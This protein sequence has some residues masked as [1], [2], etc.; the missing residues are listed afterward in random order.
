M[1]G[2]RI[3]RR[4]CQDR[5]VCC[6]SLTPQG[7]G[8]F[9]FSTSQTCVCTWSTCSRKLASLQASTAILEYTSPGTCKYLSD[10]QCP[11]RLTS[12][13]NGGGACVQRV[14][15]LTLSQFETQFSQVNGRKTSINYTW[16]L[17]HTQLTNLLGRHHNSVNVKWSQIR[18][19]IMLTSQIGNITWS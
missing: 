10:R 19:R 7:G 6:M 11:C 18:I 8:P 16:A 15:A 5:V 9:D 4:V 1:A 12:W 2:R 13:K 17:Q 3:A 14:S